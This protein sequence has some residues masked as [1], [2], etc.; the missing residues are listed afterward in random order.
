MKKAKKKT[1]TSDKPSDFLAADYKVVAY[2]NGSLLLQ[3]GADL[4][5]FNLTIHREGTDP[6]HGIITVSFA[7][8]VP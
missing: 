7:G 8:K 5:L 1:L 3:K 2:T 6:V 4:R